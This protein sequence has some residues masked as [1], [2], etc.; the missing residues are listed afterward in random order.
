M[1]ADYDAQEGASNHLGNVGELHFDA[2]LIFVS[3]DG[4]NLKVTRV[5]ELSTDFSVDAAM[6]GN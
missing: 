1:R 3:F 2:V 4:H 6:A 5:K